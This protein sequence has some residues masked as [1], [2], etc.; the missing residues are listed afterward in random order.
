MGY[1][2]D[3]YVLT[4]NRTKNFVD[5]F[6]ENFI[7]KRKEQVEVY[8]VP[9]H[10]GKMEIEFDS[11]DNLIQYLE[12]NLKIEHIIYWDNLDDK[13]PRFASCFFTDDNNLILGLS[14]TADNKT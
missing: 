1:Y 9:Q 6:L 5:G 13:E 2:A 14:C 3:C 7:P 8:E 4:N 12:S 10:R 11:A